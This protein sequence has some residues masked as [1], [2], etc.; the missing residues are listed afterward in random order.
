MKNAGLNA[1]YCAPNKI[2]EYTGLG[3][4]VLTN[5]IPGLHNLVHSYECGLSID[6][7]DTE[8]ISESLSEL[9]N[10]YDKY[11][12]GADS[13]YESVNVKKLIANILDE[14]LK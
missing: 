4:P 2:Y 6:M 5:D 1:L 14:A 9:F 8:T 12:K 13:F 10:N 11:Q 7:D 3:L